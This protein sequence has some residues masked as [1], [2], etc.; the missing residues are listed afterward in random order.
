HRARVLREPLGSSGIV[1][2]IRA[3]ELD[4]HRSV[5][6]RIEGLPEHALGVDAQL[7]NELVSRG[8]QRD[9]R[10]RPP[11]LSR[12]TPTLPCFAEDGGSCIVS[13]APRFLRR[14]SYD[15]MR[16]GY[17]RAVFE[18]LAEFGQLGPGSRILEIGCGT[19]QATLPL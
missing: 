1:R 8:D 3:Q 5:E 10:A 7:A 12:H 2:Q 18:E 4:D 9:T 15:R 11:G 13:C 14:P 19:G 17:L 16:P 6:G